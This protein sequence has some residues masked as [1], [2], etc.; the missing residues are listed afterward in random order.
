MAVELGPGF[1]IV[2]K[3]SALARVGVDVSADP[4]TYGGVVSSD[5]HLIVLGP[6]Y[7][8]QESCARLAALGL[9][10]YDDYFDLPNTGGTV[11][12]WCRIKLELRS[13]PAS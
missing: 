6:F 5:D 1:S 11:P 10:F 13:P 2:V 9:E 7:E 8:N 4:T 12:D 3:R